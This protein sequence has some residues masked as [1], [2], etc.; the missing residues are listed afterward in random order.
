MNSNLEDREAL[1][2]VPPDFTIPII[3]ASDYTYERIQEEFFSPNLP[4][5][6]TGITQ[7]W[8]AQHDWLTSG[9]ST[10][11]SAEDVGAMKANVSKGD[12]HNV[13][14]KKKKMPNW[15][16]LSRQY[17]EFEV[18][19]LQCPLPPTSLENEGGN[20]QENASEEAYGSG[21][22]TEMKFND[23]IELWKSGKGKGMYIK[24]WHL[25]REVRERAGS[26]TKSQK[27]D[28]LET[29]D[30]DNVMDASVR[31]SILKDDVN[32]SASA[33]EGEEES[34]YTIPDIFKNDWM[35]NYYTN[36]T[37]ND[38]SFV[39]F[40]TGGTFTP[41]H[42]DV[43]ESSVSAVFFLVLHTLSFHFCSLPSTRC[44]TCY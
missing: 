26:K 16:Y 24:D 1:Q 40:G 17:G 35:D 4:F 22:I 31:T 32:N 13:I 12:E 42:R 21:E 10:L 9:P 36:N 23:V 14:E 30:S 38:F 27:L 37:N 7:G 39:Y 3:S 25:R 29:M 6:I 8:P 43:C 11:S 15:D 19:V 44:D 2:T 33:E 5:I 28:A 20:Q 18:S 41:L 34:F